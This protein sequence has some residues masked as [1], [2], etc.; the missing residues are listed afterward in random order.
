MQNLTLISHPLCPYVQRAA[1]VLAEKKTSFIR[2]EIDLANKPDWF[3]SISPMGMTPVL[4]VNNDP[5]FESTVICEYLDETLEPRLHPEDPLQRAQHRSWMEFGSSILNAIGTFYNAKEEAAL[6]AAALVIRNKLALIENKLDEGPYFS[7]KDF[8]IVDAIFGPIFRYFDVFDEVDDFGIFNDLH[9]IKSWRTA[10][11][12]RPSV[13]R[14]VSE[15]YPDRLR[16]FLLAKNS[17]LSQR[18]RSPHPDNS[19]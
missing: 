18:M 14:A 9:K 5:I 10:V 16:S 11:N 17:A 6:Q 12:Q 4:V 3:L 8:C 13:R 19:A 2:K 7:G 15:D 1:I